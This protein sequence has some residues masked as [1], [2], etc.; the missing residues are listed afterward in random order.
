MRVIDA[1]NPCSLPLHVHANVSA[2][3]VGVVFSSFSFLILKTHVGNPKRRLKL[4]RRE[5]IKHQ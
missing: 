5:N 3:T 2:S 4:E 1:C